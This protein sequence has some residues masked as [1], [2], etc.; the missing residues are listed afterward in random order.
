MNPMAEIVER[1]PSV[2]EYVALIESVGFRRRDPKAIAIALDNSI[3]AVC[4]VADGGVVGCGRVI[5]DGA[6][7]YYLTDVIVRP[8]WQRHGIG[9]G[10]VASL[11]SFVEAV[12]YRNTV[13]GILA[14]SGLTR[15]YGRH[16]YKA[17]GPDAPAMVRWIN[18]TSND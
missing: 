12:P 1:R 8:E 2:A 6:L 10:I 18:R 16:G 4:A 14:L 7:H 3:Y 5:G 11:T 9:T 13:V 17:Q 15:F